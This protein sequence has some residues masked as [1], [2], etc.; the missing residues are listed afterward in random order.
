MTD[1]IL[2]HKFLKDFKIKLDEDGFTVVDKKY[3]KE[4]SGSEFS[5]IFLT[6]FDTYKTDDNRLPFEICQEWYD[7]QKKKYTKQIDE[8]LKDCQVKLGMREWFVISKDEKTLTEDDIKKMF[9]HTIDVKFIEKYYERWLSEK[10]LD[11]S[12]KIMRVF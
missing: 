4:Y 2:I 8:F 1:K 3:N 6:I 9:K 12:E 11:E 7:K 5:R 10:I